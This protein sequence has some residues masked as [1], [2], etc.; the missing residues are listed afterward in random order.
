MKKL[1]VG[2]VFKNTAP[3]QLE[4]LNLQLKFFLSTTDNF[5]H[6][7]FLNCQD[8]EPFN[9]LTEVVGYGDGGIQTSQQHCNGLCCLAEY[10]RSKRGEYENFLFIDNDA[11]PI[12]KNWINI[13]RIRMD[14]HGKTIAA[15]LRPENL[16]SRLHASVVFCKPEAVYHINFCFGMPCVDL[17]WNHEQDVGIGPYQ[18]ERREDVWPLLRT[19]KVNVHPVSCGVYFDMF[20]HHAF[21]SPTLAM[22]FRCE[23]SDY[24]THYSGDMTDFPDLHQKLR[25]DPFGFVGKLAGWCPDEYAKQ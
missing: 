7:T 4:W 22:R 24:S 15:V 2:S 3:D 6:V 10:F 5:D 16:E 14:K 8:A 9:G 23:I 12:K 19:N 18:E 20:Y 17:L 11:F 1:L 21:G 13:L 25:E